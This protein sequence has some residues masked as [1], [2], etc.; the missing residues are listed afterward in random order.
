[1]THQSRCHA[2]AALSHPTFRNW[3]TKPASTELLIHGAAD[4]DEEGSGVSLLSATLF[5]ALGTKERYIRLAFFCGLHTEAD[6]RFVGG[7]AMVKSFIAQLL[8]QYDFDLTF[9]CNND[10]SEVQLQRLRK[11]KVKDLCRLLT[12]LVRLL[13]AN[14]KVVYIIDQ[15]G[16]YECD[17]HENMMIRV[18]KTVLGQVRDSEMRC[19][20]KVLA[21][22]DE[23][24]DTVRDAFSDEDECLLD[25][26]ALEY[27]EVEEYA[28]VESEGDS[29]E[30]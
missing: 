15:I 18:L 12:C 30:E 6:D 21:T 4:A 3:L 1:M 2:E 16:T 10:G 26:E 13:P 14:T 5:Q 27:N 9:L 19:T 11:G 17:E 7:T 29:G 23:A 22:S 8:R 24:T 25:V 28:I 20:V